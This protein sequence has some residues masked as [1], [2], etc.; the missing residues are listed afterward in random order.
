MKLRAIGAYGRQAQKAD[1]SAGKDFRVLGGPYF[2]NRD[3]P[4]LLKAGF[5]EID[6][7]EI[8]PFMG[9]TVKFTVGLSE[10]DPKTEDRKA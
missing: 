3:A 10:E 1:W 6:F 9:P 8:Q 5:T 7:Y 4:E 2:S